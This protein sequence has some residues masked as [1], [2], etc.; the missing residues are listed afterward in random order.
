MR[1]KVAMLMGEPDKARA[2][3]GQAMKCRRDAVSDCEACVQSSIVSLHARLGDYERAIKAAEKIRQ[4]RLSC[5]T[6]PHTTFGTLL[7]PLFR[8]GEF[9]EAMA[10]HRRGYRL[11]QRNPSFVDEFGEH[12]QFLTL[13][14]NHTKALNVLAAHLAT[15]LACPAKQSQFEFLRAGV[16]SLD[17]VAGR[18]KRSTIKLRL[19][20]TIP[21][22]RPDGVYD[23]A[24]LQA[25]FRAAARDLAQRLDQRNGNDYYAQRLASVGDMLTEVRPHPLSAKPNSSE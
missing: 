20:P 23:I 16:L 10:L 5:Y 15:A 17:Y 1:W 25:W 7:L 24:E 18:S 11:I 21:F 3:Y 9:D 2:A 14:A 12:L 6:V 4:G 8:L 22:H 13:T 19:P